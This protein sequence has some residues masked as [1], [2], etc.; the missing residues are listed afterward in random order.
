MYGCVKNEFVKFSN[1]WL[2]LMALVIVLSLVLIFHLVTDVTREYKE[3][4]TLYEAGTGD[5]ECEGLID[6]HIEYYKKEASELRTKADLL[7][8]GGNEEAAKALLDNAD[9]DEQVIIPRYDSLLAK[10]ITAAMWQCACTNEAISAL[11]RG[12]K[13]L[14]NSF[15]E[16]LD[17]NDYL[18]YLQ[19]MCDSLKDPK[20]DLELLQ[21]YLYSFLLETG[22]VPDKNTDNWSRAMKYQD[23]MYSILNTGSETEKQ[24]LMAE[25]EWLIEAAKHNAGDPGINAALVYITGMTTAPLALSSAGLIGVLSAAAVFGVDRKRK[26]IPAVYLLPVSRI[27]INISKLLTSFIVSFAGITVYSLIYL[28][29]ALVFSGKSMFETVFIMLL[30][31]P[32]FCTPFSVFLLMTLA[33]LPVTVLVITFVFFIFSLTKNTPVAAL[34]GVAVSILLFVFKIRILNGGGE[35]YWLRYSLVSVPDWTPFILNS[36]AAPDQ[37]FLRTAVSFVIH[38]IVFVLLGLVL[39]RYSED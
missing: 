26:K 29:S 3:K 38:V 6:K 9:F 12:E 13:D 17:K 19:T 34:S 21:Y 27:K 24:K 20:D 35:V 32:V 4:I 28:I 39:E 8:K 31:R 36:L 16:A 1:K 10:G 18:L 30:G 15:D 23:N 14:R 11:A 33:L 5:E 7:L 25:N 37:S 2:P 22:S